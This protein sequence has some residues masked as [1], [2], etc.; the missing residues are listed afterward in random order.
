MSGGASTRSSCRMLNAPVKDLA[1]LVLANAV[2]SGV[3][4]APL[5]CPR[6]GDLTDRRW[7]AFGFAGGDPVGNSTEGRVGEALGYGWVRLDAEARYLVER[8]FSGGGLWSPDYQAVVAVV[9]QGVC[10]V[11][12]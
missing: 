11:A 5:R 12:S 1:I 4:A 7:W 9:G 10:K 8:G 3:D 6:P 2:P